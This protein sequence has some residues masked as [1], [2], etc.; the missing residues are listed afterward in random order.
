[1]KR[2]T[3]ILTAMS[4]VG[5]LSLTPC[6]GAEKQ[7]NHPIVFRRATPELTHSRIEI[8]RSAT[9]REVVCTDGGNPDDSILLWQIPDFE[10]Y[11]HAKVVASAITGDT[12]IVVFE[13]QM[14]KATP[15]VKKMLR[16]GRWAFEGDDYE[17]WDGKLTFLRAF[18]R[19]QNGQWRIHVSAFPETF[20]RSTWNTKIKRVEIISENDYA[21]V[22]HARWEIKKEDSKWYGKKVITD[23]DGETKKTF[24]YDTVNDLLLTMNPDGQFVYVGESDWWRDRD[25]WDVRPLHNQDMVRETAKRKR[26]EKARSLNL[27]GKNNV[28]F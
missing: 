9:E 2:N 11:E 21:V 14:N 3:A 7:V 18:I 22:Y 23:P 10:P 20:W 5:I 17:A 6:F 15:A 4:T 27:L 8:E 25:E 28:Q 13:L 19:G 26:A 12:L 16:Q 24:R 1:M